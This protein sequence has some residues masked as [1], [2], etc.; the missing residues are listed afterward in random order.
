MDTIA[1][2][3]YILNII[4][5][6]CFGKN[7]DFAAMVFHDGNAAIQCALDMIREETTEILLED[8]DKKDSEYYVDF[9]KLRKRLVEAMRVWRDAGSYTDVKVGN[10]MYSIKISKDLIF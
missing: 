3:V 10:I 8:V 2:K 1:L 6:K 7:I 4:T 9:D 5:Y